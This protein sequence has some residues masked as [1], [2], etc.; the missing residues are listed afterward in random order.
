MERSV[1]KEAG[2][3]VS[4]WLRTM[5]LTHQRPDAD[6]LGAIAACSRVLRAIGRD[7]TPFVYEPVPPRY[8]FIDALGGLRVWP[9]DTKS[10]DGRFDGILILDTCSWSQMEPAAAFLKAS[11]LPKVVMDHHAT[12][13]QLTVNS[14]DDFYA[15]DVT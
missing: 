3:R 11:R 15:I 4:G 5:V 2:R 9:G 7:A 1:L 13:D 12:H 6:A 10:L 8:K 14:T